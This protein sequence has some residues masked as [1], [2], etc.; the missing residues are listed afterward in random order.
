MKLATSCKV[1]A[2]L[3]LSVDPARTFNVPQ[4]KDKCFGGNV[5]SGRLRSRLVS[6]MSDSNS[7]TA[8]DEQK[9]TIDVDD[10]PGLSKKGVYKIKTEE[11][12][13]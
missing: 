3:T 5:G 2:L 9:S 4:Q 12:Y 7:H 11:Q 13:K 8:P 10:L 6:R 1:V